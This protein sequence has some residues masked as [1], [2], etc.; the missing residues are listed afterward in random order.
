LLAI[1]LAIEYELAKDTSAR[2]T[3]HTMT[4]LLDSKENAG[5]S[6]LGSLQNRTKV[7]PLLS[8]LYPWST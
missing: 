3:H 5:I 7:L 1:T 4:V 2:M 8:E 6:N